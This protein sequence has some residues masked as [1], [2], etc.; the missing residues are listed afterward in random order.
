MKTLSIEAIIKCYIFQACSEVNTCR[1][2]LKD[3]MTETGVDDVA[4]MSEWA[5]ELQQITASKALTI[6]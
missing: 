6:I 1:N 2:E 3:L 4:V 5:A